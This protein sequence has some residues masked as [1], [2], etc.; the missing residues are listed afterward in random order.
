M[1]Q[2]FLGFLE[3]FFLIFFIRM[4][5]PEQ[6][7]YILESA[8][9]PEHIPALMVGISQADIFMVDPFICLAKEDWLIFIGYPLEGP[10]R[11]EIF[12]DAL[13]KTIKQYGPRSTWFIAPEFPDP[14]NAWARREESDDYYRF[15]L[16][17]TNPGPN[18]IRT[19]Q[20]AAKNL[21]IVRSRVF[22][23]DHALLT[24]DLLQREDLPPRVRE[25][26]LRMKDYVAFSPTS[27]VLSARDRQDRLSAYY[28][29]DLGAEKFLTYVVGCYSKQAYV[30]HASDLLFFEMINVARDQ[31]KEYIHLGLGVNAG[32]S[33]F[34]KKWGGVPFLK[35]EFGE[36]SGRSRTAFSWIGAL[37]SRL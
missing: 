34:K 28:I 24:R 16:K 26:Y 19:A 17:A 25:L 18:L 11:A 35:Y 37:A 29:L 14:L 21:S 32:I 15:D 2:Y 5:T 27:L 4:I 30:P 13:R 12:L 10:F 22:S 33:R 8:R 9:V 6:E 7:K 36:V 3:R 1:I 23:E 31:R 20:K